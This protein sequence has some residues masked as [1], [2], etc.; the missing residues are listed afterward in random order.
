MKALVKTQKGPGHLALRD[1]PEPE[2]APGWVVLAVAYAGICGTDL[3]ILHDAH[4]YYPPVVLGHEFVGRIASVGD[5]VTG[6]QVGDRVVCEPHA[7][8]C[9]VCPLCRRGLVRLCAAKRAPGW[10]IDGGFAARVALPAGLLHRV[11]E[12]VGDLSA[13][14]CEPAAIAS[15][16]I[17][18][19]GIG[20]GDLVAVF[21]PGPIGILSALI[22]EARGAD[23]VVLVGRA[24]SAERVRAAASLGVE[25]WTGS[26]AELAGRAGE[27]TGGHGFDVVID[28]TGSPAAV[29]DGIA[30]LR[31]SGRMATVGVA[32]GPSFDFPW[33]EAVFKSLE[34]A[35]SFS[36]GYEDWRGALSLMRRGLVPAEAMV[37][38][39]PLDDWERAFEAVA[40]RSVV[41]ALLRPEA[42]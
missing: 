37:T 14:V 30:L 34:L 26:G 3:H 16:A 27:A 29:G 11:P 22:A 20:P 41:K 2:A 28:T 42:G 25:C 31:R 4:P 10:G 38:V 13:A 35:F 12:S 17:A 36:S 18:R 33:N 23:R 6:W 21:G 1:V 19:V 40:S 15:R 5:G 9:G 7:R 32:A 8:H 24:S 39:F